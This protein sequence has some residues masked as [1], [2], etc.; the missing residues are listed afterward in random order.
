MP[1]SFTLPNEFKIVE[2]IALATDAAGRTATAVSLKNCGEAYI[3]V[4]ITQGN[5]AT[6][7]L[8][9]RQCTD[10]TGSGAKALTA[11]VP[12]WANLDTSVND[13]LV[14]QTDALSFTTDAGVK[15]KQVLFLIDPGQLDVEGGFDCLNFTTGASNV[16]NLT[17]AVYLLSGIRYQQTTPPTARV[18]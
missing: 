18:D 15:N 12:I 3:L 2:A 14:R 7:A 16:A 8:T 6:I 11:A 1:S 10:V 13:T 9:P 5:A 17:G 4:N